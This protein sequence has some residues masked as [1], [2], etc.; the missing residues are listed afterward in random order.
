MWSHLSSHSQLFCSSW[1]NYLMGL[2]LALHFKTRR[3]L[4]SSWSWQQWLQRSLWIQGIVL[5][6]KTFIILFAYKYNIDCEFITFVAADKLKQFVRFCFQP[7]V[8]IA[9]SL[10]LGDGL[11]NLIK[12]IAI[13]TREMINKGSK[14]S[15]LPIVMES[16][17]KKS[18]RSPKSMPVMKQAYVCYHAKNVM[19]L[20][21]NN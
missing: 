8:F 10:I 2:P 11:Y 5:K 4:V 16:M 3:R 20:Q 21:H 12:I 6:V 15:N 14:T 13:T 7:Q 19:E 9:I 1:C 17:G 18:L